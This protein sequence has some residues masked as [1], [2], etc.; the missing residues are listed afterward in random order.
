MIYIAHRGNLFGA[1]PDLENAPS[2]LADALQQGY[3]VELDVRL[4]HDG[5]RLGHDEGQHPIN[6]QWLQRGGLWMHAKNPAAVRGLA[7][8]T[9]RLRWLWHVDEEYAFTSWGELWTLPNSDWSN[10]LPSSIVIYLGPPCEAGLRR[11][12]A[13]ICSDWAAVWKQQR[14][15]AHD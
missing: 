1:R 10:V 9:P 2:Y 13:G 3:H 4:E 14:E 12:C 5:W 7:A 8:V 6:W 15:A 11:P